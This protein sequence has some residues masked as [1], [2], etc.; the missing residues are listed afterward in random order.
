VAGTAGRQRYLRN[1]RYG[2]LHDWEILYRTWVSEGGGRIESDAVRRL[3]RYKTIREYEHNG[4]RQKT[5]DIVRC[6][7]SSAFEALT[8]SIG[9]NKKTDEWQSN[10]CRYFEF[11]RYNTN[12]VLQDV[13]ASQIGIN[14]IF[15]RQVGELELCVLTANCLKNDGIIYIGDLVRKSEEEMRRIPNSTDFVPGMRLQCS[16]QLGARKWLFSPP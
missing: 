12:S 10:R 9:D 3:R 14:V 5:R 11:G 15:L 16:P 4:R 6:P 2:S 1:R 8:S 7:F 13:R